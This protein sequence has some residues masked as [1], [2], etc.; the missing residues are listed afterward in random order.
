L[1]VVKL[2]DVITGYQKHSSGVFVVA[3]DIDTETDLGAATGVLFGETPANGGT[4]RVDQGLDTTEVSPAFAIDSDL[5][6]TQYI[7]QIDNRLGNIISAV[8]NSRAVVSFIDDDNIAS[9]YF[10]ADS[11]L[12]YVK[13]ITDIDLEEI[14]EDFCY[15]Y[16]GHFIERKN[17]DLL[18]KAFYET[19][20]NKKKKP[21]LLLKTSIM[22]TSYMDREEILK[23]IKSIKKTINSEDIPNIYL[24]NGDFT[25]PE[26]NQIYNHPKV[27]AMIN[28]NH[29]EGF[30]RP[31]LEFT[32][33]KKPLITSGWSG[34]LDFLSPEF[35]CLLGGNLVDLPPSVLNQWFVE[36]SKWFEP[37]HGQIGFYLKDVF[38]NYK[39]YTEKAKRQA[40]KS[41]NEFSWDKM[42]EKLDKYLIKYVPEFPQE[43]QLKLPQMKK[44]SLPP[45]INFPTLNKIES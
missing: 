40:F 20:K 45:K 13:E 17:V 24:L 2:N 3:V 31:L 41:K 27:K 33:S 4:I 12:D 32:L 9:Y 44:I 16:L 34:Q 5:I 10:S 43:I 38:E 21:A 25:D 1:P 26:I 30:G 6:E 35:T 23:K 18:I 42:K 37:D 19:F 29:G 36:G 15:L 11:D 7:L 39:N 28:I 22:G 14:K 8:D